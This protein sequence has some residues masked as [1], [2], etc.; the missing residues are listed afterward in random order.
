MYMQQ[1]W[2]DRR[3][4]YRGVTCVLFAKQVKWWGCVRLQN[5]DSPT[6]SSCE[7]HRGLQTV[8]ADPK[9]FWLLPQ[10]LKGSLEIYGTKF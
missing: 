9:C 1:Q 5:F 2:R 10:G 7:T 8:A 3:V 4:Q 6:G